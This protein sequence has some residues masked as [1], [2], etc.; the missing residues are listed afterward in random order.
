M[1]DEHS[2]NPLAPYNK[3]IIKEDLSPYSTFILENVEGKNTYKSKKMVSSFETRVDYICHYEN[4]QLYLQ[5]GMKLE[6]VGRVLSFDQKPFI[7]KYVE[8]F[9]KLRSMS[10]TVFDNNNLKKIINSLYGKFLENTR[11]RLKIDLCSDPEKLQKLAAGPLFISRKIV[12]GDLVAVCTKNPIAKM[13][14]PYLIGTCILEK[15][16]RIMYKSFYET[17]LPHFGSDNLEMGTS[18]TDS[19]LFQSYSENMNDDFKQLKDSFDF[20]NL[21]KSHELY[22]ETKK[23]ALYHFKDETKRKV[24]IIDAIC[25]RSKC[26]SLKTTGEDTQRIKGIGKAAVKTYV[27][28]D[29]FDKSLH[30]CT[31]H[32]VNVNMIRTINHKLSTFSIL[33]MA[34]CPFD[35]KRYILN[36]GI[37]SIPFGHYSIR[38]TSPST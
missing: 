25:L 22:D 36:C 19:Y 20:S 7:K 38:V 21:D 35:S 12:S 16:K 3:T 15:S 30:K 34:L 29:D 8:Y 28:H 10:T 9:T 13:D 1:H 31:I 17:I 11:N 33:K 26:Y 24:D 37:H 6:S 14:K 4:L 27:T 2:Q 23:S 32:K 5:H 18:D